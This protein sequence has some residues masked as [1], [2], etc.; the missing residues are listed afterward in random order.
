M[1]RFKRFTV[2]QPNAAMKVGTDGVLLGAWVEVR[3]TDR[4]ILDIGTGTGVIALMMAQRCEGA[5]VTALE[6]D[7]PSAA[8]ARDNVAASP[9]SGRVEVV[10]C[11][12]AL[13]DTPERFDLIVSNPPYFVDSLLPP[14]S[15]RAAARHAASLPFGE[16][17]RT[18]VR[19]L[20]P[21]GRFALILPTD[22]SRLFCD[23]A[24]GVLYP[25]RITEVCSTP[26]SGVIRLL[27]EFRAEPVA[28]A[29]TSC[30][31]IDD[32][33]FT[34]EYRELTRDFYLKF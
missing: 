18:V 26:R 14:D 15:G 10:E 1:F 21:G 19:L 31:V 17:V 13:Y 22:E 2:R 20:A 27:T 8:D 32:G 3:D 5:R 7:G 12:A 9:W 16:L 34:P 28:E 23:A 11:D 30:L 4:R 25:V 33:G 29:T 6:I 24:R